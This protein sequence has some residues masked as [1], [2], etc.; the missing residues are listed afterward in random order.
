VLF[1]PMSH[2][3]SM[4]LQVVSL[5]LVRYQAICPN[6]PLIGINADLMVKRKA[7]QQ[8]KHKPNKGIPLLPVT[9]E[10]GNWWQIGKYL[11]RAFQVL[12]AVFSVLSAY[13]WLS[14]QISLTA[15]SP[16]NG[17]ALSAPFTVKNSS[18]F[19]IE[20]VEASCGIISL[21]TSTQNSIDGLRTDFYME[22]VP[23]MEPGES[24]SVYC[25]TDRGIHIGGSTL[26]ADVILTTSYRASYAPWIKKTKSFRFITVTDSRASGVQWQ[27][28]AQ[29]E[30]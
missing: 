7:L 19:S 17:N 12:L 21:S 14:P 25:G 26:H 6:S 28:K 3:F 30:R 10:T 11:L 4:T 20:N 27:P 2:Y 16:L 8:R 29:S 23:E 5:Q 13:T 9:E 1:W 24:S 15:T 22:P 18:N